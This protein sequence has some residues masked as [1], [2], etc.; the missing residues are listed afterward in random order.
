[1][2]R[3][4][5]W[6]ILIILVITILRLRSGGAMPLPDSYQTLPSG[7]IRIQVKLETIPSDSQGEDW[8]LAKETAN[9]YTVNMFLNGRENR[10]FATRKLSS[11]T[12]TGK[13]YVSAGKI[14]FAKQN[15]HATKIFVNPGGKTGYIEFAKN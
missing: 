3:Q 10:T 7:D 8:N 11:Q 9:V 6:T 12:S 14:R 1:M 13:T 4:Y 15:Y 2:R 5:L